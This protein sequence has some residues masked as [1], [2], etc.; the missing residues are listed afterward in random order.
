MKT[1]EDLASLLDDIK[2]DE[3]PA[4]KCSISSKQLF[5]FCNSNIVKKRYKSF[6]IRKKSGGTRTINAPTYQ[7]SFILHSLNVLFKALYTPSES[8]MGFAEGKSIVENAKLHVGHHYV[9]NVDLKDFFPSIS[10]GR[11]WKRI[12]LP[13]FNFPEKI[14]NVVAG[15]CCAED[16]DLQK[17][18]LPQGAPTSPL[19]TNAICDSMDR[20][21]KGVANRFGLHYSRYA[22]D[23]TFSSM[24]NIY[25]EDG[26]FFKELR[27]VISAQGF[28]MNEKKTRLQKDGQRQE[29]T[30]LTVNRCVNVAHKYSRDLRCLLHAWEKEGYAKAY[31]YFYFHY[32]KE[33]GYIKKGEPVMEN[34]I[35]GKLNYLRMVK[36]NNNEAYQKLLDRY[37]K[38]Q[39]VIFFDE[40]FQHSYVQPY[41]VAQFE[42]YFQT[43][44]SLELTPKHKLV[45]KCVLAET[46]KTIHIYEKTQKKLVDKLLT[47]D[48]DT[49]V[50]SPLLQKC[51]VTLCRTK[52]KNYWLITDYEPKRS[53]CFSI[54]NSDVD[55][56]LL[57]E[58]WKEKGI[59]DAA[60]LFS[61]S[62]GDEEMSAKQARLKHSEQ[63]KS[64]QKKSQ[65]NQ[66]AVCK[67]IALAMQKLSDLP[68]TTVAVFQKSANRSKKG[69]KVS[70][71][72][73][74]L[75]DGHKK[76]CSANLSRLLYKDVAK[77]LEV[78]EHRSEG[79]YS[80]SD[81]RGLKKNLQILIDVGAVV[82]EFDSFNREKNSYPVWKSKEKKTNL[83]LGKIG[84]YT[85]EGST[86]SANV[87]E[88]PF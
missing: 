52:G 67:R 27:H 8:A 85:I 3:F 45:S 38:L 17:N 72:L 16:K 60:E 26:D 53:K 51:F 5:H 84:E 34:V 74:F 7:L 86:S 2:G 36:G 81:I 39:Q 69:V 23:M 40:D 12:Q 19:L 73:T 4:S 14:A 61:S 31:C 18:V 25:Q 88:V 54:Q 30:G 79:N 75:M 47:L 37:N 43:K 13:P 59:E 24:H 20:K 41:S 15:L 21:L 56:D 33:K 32:K 35:G 6:L 57:L 22:D 63:L 83:V 48:T 10:Q 76:H 29:V 46:E 55:I 80:K 50:E 64:T 62:L 87:E 78:T 77:L 71:E 28:V 68:V 42:E 9:L 65:N 49:K 70:C 1:V 44:L 82:Y 66:D 58:T 11:V